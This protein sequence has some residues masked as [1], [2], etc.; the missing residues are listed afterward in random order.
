VAF[1]LALGEEV[2]RVLRN[3]A[4]LG[5]D[6]VAVVRDLADALRLGLGAR[7]ACLDDSRLLTSQCID[8][9][10][11][12]FGWRGVGAARRCGLVLGTAQVE[13]TMTACSVSMSGWRCGAAIGSAH[14][15][16]G[17][18]RRLGCGMP[19]RAV[20]VA[21][22][23][24]PSANTAMVGAATMVLTT[25]PATSAVASCTDTTWNTERIA[26]GLAAHFA[27]SFQ[28]SMIASARSW[29]AASIRN[30]PPR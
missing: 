3:S 20:P 29:S 25:V 15:A 14:F 6:L 27:R 16:V 19:A 13:V 22:G 21:I 4:D 11:Q 7:L 26:H 8:L 5:D 17:R 18:S 9:I 30:G 2:S 24:L 12:N 10:W 1:R 23:S 28:A